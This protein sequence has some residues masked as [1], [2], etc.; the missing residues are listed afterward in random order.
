MD[1][2]SVSKSISNLLVQGIISKNAF[3]R[4]HFKFGEK[5]DLSSFLNN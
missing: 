2:S 3:E 1:K 4:D 5:V